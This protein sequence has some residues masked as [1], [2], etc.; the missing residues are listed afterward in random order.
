LKPPPPIK[1]ISIANNAQTQI[2]AK[3]NTI[4]EYVFFSWLGNGDASNSSSEIGA[5]QQNHQSSQEPDRS[6]IA[7]KVEK[8]EENDGELLL[9]SWK[10]I[11]SIY[12]SFVANLR[13]KN[14]KLTTDLVAQVE[15]AEYF[16]RIQFE[17]NELSNASSSL[18]DSSKDK[19]VVHDSSSSSIET[20][21]PTIINNANLNNKNSDSPRN[22]AHEKSGLTKSS[23]QIVV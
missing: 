20:N 15:A 6:P 14:S 2:P 19:F 1:S 13:L 7:K 18:H 21:G 9:L 17:K 3:N 11:N 16:S 12:P 5:T 22:E 4:L 8:I 10:T 23:T